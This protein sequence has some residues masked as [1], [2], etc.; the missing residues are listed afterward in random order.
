MTIRPV[1]RSEFP[2]PGAELVMG[3]DLDLGKIRF[4]VARTVRDLKP[5]TKTTEPGTKN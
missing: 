5:I 1:T 3:Q 2:Q 4:W